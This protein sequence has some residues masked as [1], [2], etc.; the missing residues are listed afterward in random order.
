MRNDLQQ[1]LTLSSHLPTYN[2]SD[3]DTDDKK[4]YGISSS[5]SVETRRNLIQE[6][7]LEEEDEELEAFNM[8]EPGVRLGRLVEYLRGEFGYCFWCKFRYEDEGMEGCPGVAEED[9]D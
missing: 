7:E 6:E 1:S 4:A 2:D 8:L 5:T 3:L 9:H